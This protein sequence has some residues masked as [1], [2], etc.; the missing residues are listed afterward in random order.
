MSDTAASLAPALR[1]RTF[2]K[3]MVYYDNRRVTIDCTVRDLSDTGAR[4][5]FTSAVTV[6]DNIELHIP[7][8]ER[9]YKAIVRRRDEYEI[10]VSFEDQRSGDPRRVADADVTQRVAMLEQEVAQLKKLVRKMRDKLMP[11]DT[12]A[13]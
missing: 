13:A 12:D 1:V 4:I 2:L 10:G 7:A 5:A 9:T 11:N 8:K 3:G 6:P